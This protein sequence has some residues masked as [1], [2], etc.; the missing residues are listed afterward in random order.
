ML[1]ELVTIKTRAEKVQRVLRNEVVVEMT[2]SL[3]PEGVSFPKPIKLN[4]VF[5]LMGDGYT[6]TTSYPDRKVNE[7]TVVMTYCYKLLNQP[8]G[9]GHQYG[10]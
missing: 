4:Q 9:N 3:T 7:G 5:R 2:T 6:M 10:A 1:P 8:V